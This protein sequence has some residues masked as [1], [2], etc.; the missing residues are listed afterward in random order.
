MDLDDG[1]VEQHRL[2]S[3]AQDPLPLQPVEDPVEHLVLQAAI[4]A[5]VDGV[6]CRTGPGFRHLQPCSATYVQDGVA[7]L[8][9]LQPTLPRCTGRC[10]A[11]RAYQASVLSIR[12]RKKTIGVDTP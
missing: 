6:P 5:R 4:H 8:Q 3:E 2:Q 9:V 11:M 1:A 7:H 12:E 10:R